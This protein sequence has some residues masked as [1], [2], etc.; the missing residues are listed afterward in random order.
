MRSRTS[1]VND[2]LWNS[3]VVEVRDLFAKD[4]VLQKSRAAAIGPERVLIVGNRVAL[5]GCE[6]G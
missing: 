3:L 1:R 2:T 5:I 4:E 6:N